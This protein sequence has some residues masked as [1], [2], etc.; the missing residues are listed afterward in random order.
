MLLNYIPLL[1]KRQGVKR[2]NFQKKQVFVAAMLIIPG[3]E[4]KDTVYNLPNLRYNS[5]IK[6]YRQIPI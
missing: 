6:K 1:G 2:K 3:K 5:I 4:Q